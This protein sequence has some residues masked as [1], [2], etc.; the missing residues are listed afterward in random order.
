MGIEC[1]RHWNLAV[2]ECL[3]LPPESGPHAV[4]VPGP[5]RHV[6]KERLSH[7]RTENSAGHGV[8]DPPFLDVENDPN[9]EPLSIR[10][11]ESGAV[12]LRLIGDAI[13]ES[14]ATRSHIG[15]GSSRSIG[16]P[17]LSGIDSRHHLFGH[18]DHRLTAEF[19]ISPVL[20]G[21]E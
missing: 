9:C 14:H 10:Q 1:Q 21:V 17:G 19:A 18:Q 15:R 6:R 3:E 11:L 13:G 12:D 2:R 16:L 20:P 5:V 8:F 7:R 4:F